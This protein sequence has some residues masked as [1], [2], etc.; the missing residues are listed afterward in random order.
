MKH[1][2]AR[3][4]VDSFGLQGSEMPGDFKTK[5]ARCSVHLA[6]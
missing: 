3:E 5:K 2:D 4:K 6:F 1:D